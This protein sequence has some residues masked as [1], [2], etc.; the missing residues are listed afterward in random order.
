MNS[1]VITTVAEAEQRLQREFF[2]RYPL[3]SIGPL[4]QMETADQ[5]EI[6]E[7]QPVP[8]ML[9]VWERL[10]P[11]IGQRLLAALPAEIV[12]EWDACFSSQ[13]EI[14]T[15]TVKSAA[16]AGSA[17]TRNCSGLPSA[18]EPDASIVTTGVCD[19]SGGAAC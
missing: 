4:E 7:R 16:G 15:P 10:S 14:E 18:A 11:D 19:C 12:T 1:N 8:A 6:F 13:P 5:V 3:A 2:S 17:R 9:P